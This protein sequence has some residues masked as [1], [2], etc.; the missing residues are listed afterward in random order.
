MSADAS[1]YDITLAKTGLGF[2]TS[3]TVTERSAGLHLFLQSRAI[4]LLEGKYFQYRDSLVLF[5]RPYS[6]FSRIWFTRLVWGT[7]SQTSRIEY[8][9]TYRQKK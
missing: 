4:S 2:G 5:T 9:S 6:P 7:R 1:S 3:T 8:G